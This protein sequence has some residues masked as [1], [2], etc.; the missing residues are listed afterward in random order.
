[1]VTADMWHA[2][3]QE[4]SSDP[5][6]TADTPVVIDLTA[7]TTPLGPLQ[8]SMANDWLALLPASRGALITG[9]G[10]PLA[11]AGAIE[12]MTGRRLRAFTDAAV[13]LEWLRS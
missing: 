1:M 4:V 2:L 6:F 11:V 8:E 13:A 3:L 12:T 7:A 5:S 9:E 10:E